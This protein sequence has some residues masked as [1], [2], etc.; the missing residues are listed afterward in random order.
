MPEVK[1]AVVTT[2]LQSGLL[3]YENS[4]LKRI[5][6]TVSGDFFEMFSWKFLKGN[7]A[8]A[9]REP[10]SIVLTASAA[11]ALF[12]NMDAIG[13]IIRINDFESAT[14]SGENVKVTAILADLPSNS[15][16]Q[17]DYIRP[18]DYSAD[19]VK[20]YMDNWTASSWFVF[21]ETNP[22]TDM[23]VVNKKIDDLKKRHDPVDQK[24]STFFTFP[25]P[26]WRLYSDFKDG[27]NVGGLITYVKLFTI[28]A[29]VILLI[30][31]I[32]FMNLTTARSEKRAKEVGVRKTLG[33]SKKQLILQFFS[34]SMILT[35][36]AFVLSILAVYPLLPFFNTLVEKQMSLDLSQPHFWIGALVIIVI[37]GVVAG[38]YPAL[39]LSSFNP[40]NVL[41]GIF[42]A[43]KKAVLPRQVLVAGQFVISILLI[44]ATIIVYQQIQHIKKRDLGYNAE[45]LIVIPGSPDTQRN[46]EIIKQELLQAGVVKAI[47]RTSYPITEV[48]SKSPA[49]EWEGKPDNLQILFANLNTDKSFTETMDVKIV[50]GNN[51][52]GLPSDS[53]LMLLNKAAVE[54]MGLRN[55][56]G[57]QI[58]FE[59]K[60]YQVAGITNNIIMESPF[61]PVDPMMVFFDPGKAPFISIR[62]NATAE[63]RNVLGAVETIFKKYNPAVPFEYQ[64]ADQEFG[65]KFLREELISKLAT[66]FAGLAIF[67]CCM[68]LAGLASFTIEKRIREIGIRKVLGAS[69]QQLLMLISKEFLKLVAIAFVIAVPLAWWLMYNWLQNYTFRVN[70]S[71]WL[72]GAVGIIVL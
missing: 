55:P 45:N 8:T 53:S 36:I 56:V 72:F 25:M 44:S 34:E 60:A 68:G 57:K 3:T 39:Y 50:E 65:K 12:G 6:Y 13:K 52:S 69:V 9:I 46:F 54:V 28:V 40:V 61:Q 18:F 30:A 29:L 38:S 33:S 63:L 11:K 49:P 32:N 47:T 67:I 20:Q 48:W 2:Y 31:C 58:R 41:K 24:I 5:G 62:L 35:V 4:D 70:I 71:I 17:F 42:A 51:F 15:T 7:A 14:G 43:G 59:G 1:R 26:K 19:L 10:N 37:T 21:V 22:G 66:I 23:Q 64:F 16:L 27:K